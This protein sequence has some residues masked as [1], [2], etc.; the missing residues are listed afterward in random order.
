M[1][2]FH[3]FLLLL[4]LSLSACKKEDAD[5]SGK[6]FGIPNANTGLDISQC[7]PL[8]MCKNFSSKTFSSAE[9]NALRAW[10]LTDTIAELTE[11]PYLFPPQQNPACLCAVVVDNEQTKEYHLENFSSEEEAKAVGAIPTHFDACGTCSSLADFTVYAENIDIGADVRACAILN[12]SQPFEN[13]VACIE[14][15]GFSKPCA[16]IWAYNARNTQQLCFDICIQDN[17]Y[18]KPDG[19][20]GDCLDCDERLSGPVFK[21]VA[22]RTRR[23]TGIASSICRLCSEVQIVEHNYPL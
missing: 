3:L 12:L 18:N 6:L 13:L 22:G 8:C 1:K 21:A 15:L 17:I 14:D 23:N 16:Q 9:L 11:N 7:T 4:L 10:V 2:N 5:C 19:S 20:L